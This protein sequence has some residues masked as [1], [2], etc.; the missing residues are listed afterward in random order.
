MGKNEKGSYVR[1]VWGSNEQYIPL[2]W[3][4]MALCSSY[5]RQQGIIGLP[6]LINLVFTKSIDLLYM[7]RGTFSIF[8]ISLQLNSMM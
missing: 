2:H 3:S 4:I 5:V 1:W 7:V 8:Q 6:G